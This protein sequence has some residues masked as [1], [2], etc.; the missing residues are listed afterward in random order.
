MAQPDPYDQFGAVVE[1]APK[2][3][4]DPQQQFQNDVMSN[5]QDSDVLRAIDASLADIKAGHST[6]FWGRQFRGWGG[7]NADN[8]AGDLRTVGSNVKIDKMMAMKAASPTG[9]TG[10]GNMTEQEGQS[11]QDSIASLDQNLDAAHLTTNLVD[12]ERHYRSL[13]ALKAGED[14]RDPAVQKKYGIIPALPAGTAA[15]TVGDANPPPAGPSGGNAA[16]GA[17]K[18]NPYMGG[19]N[20]PGGD[21]SIGLTPADAQYRQEADPALAGVNAHV[22]DM[23]KAGANYGDVVKYLQSVGVNPS[24]VSN[25]TGG[26]ENTNV[27]T[28]RQRHPEYRGNYNVSVD[29]RLVPMSSTRQFFNK[30]SQSPLGAFGMAAGDAASFG[31]LDNMMDNPGLARAAISQVE[32]EHPWAATAGMMAGG[33]AAGAGLEYGL[34]KAGVPA[35]SS[36]G[37]ISLAPRAIVGDALYGAGYGAGS[38]DDSNRVKGALT[39]A[40]TA[41]PAGMFGRK[42]VGAAASLISPTGGELRPLYDAGVRP[43]IGQRFAT[44]GPLGKTVN[45]FEQG[46]QSIPLLGGMVRGARDASRDQFER[47]AFD[48]VLSE[49][50]PFGDLP[51]SLP[52]DMSLGTQ[53]HAFMQ[54]ATNEAY[55]RARAGMRF[56]PDQA[57]QADRAAFSQSLGSGIFSGDQVAQITK[58]LD[59]SLTSR[60]QAGRGALSGDAYKQAASD[61][62]TASRKLSASDPLVAGALHDYGQIV[63]AAAR[64]SSSPQANELMDAVDRAYAK[65]VRVEQAA[66]ARGG[67][68]GRF[69]PTQFD[70]SVQQTSGGV[71][72]RAYLRGDALMGDYASAGKSLVDTLPNSGTADRL[73]IDR[74]LAGGAISGGLTTHPIATAGALTATLPYAP[75]V[76]AMV[77]GAMAPSANAAKQAAADALRKLPRGMF[78]RGLVVPAIQYAPEVPDLLQ[79]R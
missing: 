17:P 53:P 36:L 13:A 27:F 67:D 74:L 68:T 32:G 44:S 33:A 11:L 78:G 70:R 59:N 47:G 40:A 77:G 24:A 7:T 58:I 25:L 72:S 9:A 8:L 73:Q 5:M 75:G 62:A 45:T 20:T 51:T 79:L 65:Q 39:G 3:T 10:F 52:K 76:R 6:G 60:L 26:D 35:I 23:I 15:P 55:S 54:N 16:G 1:T 66:A 14:P 63:D 69:S 56:V 34:G 48:S 29:Q 19:P 38:A 57:Y 41:V 31:T 4:I 49:L 28:F 61:I 42:V 30:V 46:M 21:T 64:R 2:G 50:K 37:G 18:P 22:S 43:T 12:V 71:R